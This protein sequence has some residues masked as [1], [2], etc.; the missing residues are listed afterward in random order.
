MI[1]VADHDA[2]VAS[3]LVNTTQQIGG[4]LGTAILVTIA[5]SAT[6]NYLTAHPSPAADSQALAAQAAVNGYTVA[7]TW[8]AGV[9]AAAAVAVG[10]LVKARR[11]DLAKQGDTVP[12]S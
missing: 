7:F 2:G 10:L 12:T 9:L 5:T 6:T 4:A 11:N 3:A 8:S 1:G